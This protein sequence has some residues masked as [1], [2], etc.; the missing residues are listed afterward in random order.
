[1]EYRQRPSTAGG[2]GGGNLKAGSGILQ[3][4]PMFPDK[5]SRAAV[6]DS[7]FNFSALPSKNLEDDVG[8]SKKF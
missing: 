3:I 4:T 1:M 5:A 2:L 7:V 6:G 8:Y